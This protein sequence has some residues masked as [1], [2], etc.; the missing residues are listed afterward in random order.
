MTEFFDHFRSF[1]GSDRRFLESLV[2]EL[3][4]RIVQPQTA[5]AS[6]NDP[7]SGVFFLRRGSVQYMVNGH[8]MATYSMGDVFGEMACLL[9]LNRTVGKTTNSSS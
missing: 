8:F 2:N 4:T 9:G 3:E 5:L 7:V 1:S 6:E